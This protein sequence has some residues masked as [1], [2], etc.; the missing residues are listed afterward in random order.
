MVE[1]YCWALRKHWTIVLSCKFVLLYMHGLGLMSRRCWHRQLH[2]YGL[3]ASI[4][5]QLLPFL[6]LLWNMRAVF[7]LSTSVCNCINKGLIDLLKEDIVW[8]LISPISQWLTRNKEPTPTPLYFCS[9]NCTKIIY[10]WIGFKVLFS[11]YS[12]CLPPLPFIHNIS[13]P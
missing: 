9:V 4:L 11:L 13:W 7:P 3:T 1:N 2:H 5:K 12:T 10:L 8:L 6:F